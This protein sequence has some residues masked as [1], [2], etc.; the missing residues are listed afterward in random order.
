MPIIYQ[1]TTVPAI[2]SGT[3]EWPC[4]NITHV[5]IPI[6]LFLP[7]V[8]V[9]RG[10]PWIEVD[11]ND[12]LRI[13]SDDGHL[14]QI[15]FDLTI[16]QAFTYEFMFRPSALPVDLSSLS[17]SR[18]FVGGF[19]KQ[20]NGGG[21]LISRK[22]IAIVGSFA[23]S[24][25][26]LP[27]SQNLF[28]E[29]EDLYILRVA[30]DGNTNVMNVYI[31]KYDDA[32]IGGQQLRYTAPAPETPEG[33][34]DHLRVEIVG[35]VGHPVTGKFR[36]FK[37][38]CSEASVPNKRP[39]ADA[40]AD[41]TANIGSAVIHDGSNSYDPEGL[42]LSYFWA[43]KEVPDGSRFKIT[44]TGSTI[45]D[46]DTDGF[47]TIL[48]TTDDV[49]SALNAPLLQ[50]GDHLL[51]GNVLYVVSTD[52]WTL[53]TS[54]GKYDRGGTFDPNELVLTTDT[55][56]D[57]ITSTSWSVFHTRTYFDDSSLPAP[58]AIPDVSGLYGV[59]LVVNDGNLNSVPA[60]AL[61]NVSQTSV[62][63]GCIPDVSFIWNHL[64]DFWGLVEDRDAVEVVWSG[65]AQA[66]A[67]QL[68]TAWQVD[69]NKSLLDI[70]RVFQRR[71]LNYS[72]LLEDDPDTATIR[73]VRGPIISQNLA[74]GAA[75]NGL[76]LQLVLDAANIETV[77]FS[78]VNP[79]S[80][81]VL[82]NQINAQMG[83]SGAQSKLATKL[84]VG[85]YEYLV[86]EH[87]TLLRVRPAG[88]ANAVLGFS[89]SAYTQNEL[90][91]TS[92]G[93][94][95]T[96]L[97]RSFVAETT[98]PGLDFDAEGVGAYDILIWD[99]AGYRILK[100]AFDPNGEVRGLSLREDL[101]DSAPVDRKPWR[102][103]SVV[104]STVNNFTEAMI[105]AGDLV[106]FEVKLLSGGLSRDVYC[107]VLGVANDRLGFDPQPLLEAYAGQPSQY[108][109][110]FVGVKRVNY[111]PVSELVTEIPRLQ[112]II[113]QPPSFL[114]MNTDYLVETVGET[115]TIHFRAGTFSLLDPPPDT[116]WAEVTYLD[117]R[118][119]IEANFGRLVNFPVEGLKTR[120][121]NLDYLS[122]VR[123]LWWAYFSGPAI[124]KVKTG[125]QILLGLPFAE[126]DGIIESISTSFSAAEGRILIRDTDNSAVTRSYFYPL[127]AGLAIND[128]TGELIKEGDSIAQFSPLSGGIDVLDYKNDP[129]WIK[130][131]LSQGYFTEVEK[132]FRFLVRGDVDTFNIVNMIF[133]IDFAKK[134][135]PH[136]TYPIFVFLKNI[137]ETEVDVTDTLSMAL[138]LAFFDSSCSQQSGAYRWDDINGSGVVQHNYDEAPP[139]FIFDSQRLYP[140]DIVFAVVS[141]PLA[142]G[143]WN[144]DSLWAFDNGDIDNDLVSD[145]LVP[146]SGPNSSPPPPN[147]PLIGNITFDASKLAGTYIRSKRL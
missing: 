131:Y 29:S 5:A 88:T 12:D 13:T 65:F 94:T 66:A 78:G 46:G 19:D 53:N 4:L 142:S 40:G 71:W 109:T 132:F 108:R 67:A 98:P 140:Q 107:E 20:D 17:Q 54:N 42:P 63:L 3:A 6:I 92:G 118:P 58:T 68:L 2:T 139:Q 122:A 95:L 22:G 16:S 15:Q 73:V 39:I 11:G 25:F 119:N 38:H 93:I 91:G 125:V 137:P 8:T 75:V 77:T 76:T 21:V 111:I 114:S 27:G 86:L 146:L 135:R 117:N 70:Q 56:P 143:A 61:L 37:C 84:V 113:Y 110:Q 83:F 1:F 34:I 59:Q 10:S 81:D 138:R 18:F 49:F 102:V 31:T 124:S 14:S 145:D 115:N 133:A 100:T 57:N 36:E 48:S 127:K 121:D 60:E 130:P 123:G 45:D 136:Y 89:T 147:G 28:T 51:L 55:L 106:K 23:G 35:T 116:L 129:S 126:V 90:Q 47:T 33:H 41:Q 64:S 7:D 43:L 69:Y 101:P 96:G 62:V 80:V 79:L 141:A 74:G 134:I 104:I 103:P 85:A 112:E 50:P 99:G 44:G 24:A 120:T 9:T 30:V 97:T 26:I 128:A 105:T 82:V 72:L 144:Y 32:L 52:R 87:A